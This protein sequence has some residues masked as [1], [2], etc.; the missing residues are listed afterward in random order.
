HES[1]GKCIPCRVGTTQLVVQMEK[2]RETADAAE[3]ER[4]LDALRQQAEI[5]ARTSLCPLG[6]SPILPIG[7]ALKYFRA[8]LR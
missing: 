1:C 8:E 6:Q 7:S 4:L 5:M 3:R 2:I